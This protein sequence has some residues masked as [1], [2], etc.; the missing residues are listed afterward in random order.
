MFFF[1]FVIFLVSTLL[2]VLS[3]C[4]LFSSFSAVLST[5]SNLG[6]GF[7]LASDN[8]MLSNIFSKWILIFTMLFGRLELF[9]L[10]VLLIPFF[11]KE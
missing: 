11:W 3:G 5:L 2:L 6:I 8:Y 1:Y 4:D 7:G 10:L 9:A